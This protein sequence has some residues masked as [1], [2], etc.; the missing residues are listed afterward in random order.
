MHK[1]AILSGLYLHLN[2][3]ASHLRRQCCLAPRDVTAAI[4]GA[5]GDRSF[6]VAILCDPIIL[7]RI[8]FTGGL[9]RADGHVVGVPF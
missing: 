3:A 5:D 6:W 7:G 9:Q 8:A 4:A 2:G 1:C